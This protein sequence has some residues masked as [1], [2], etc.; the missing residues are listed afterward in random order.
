ME[1]GRKRLR[2]LHDFCVSAIRIVMK[3][4]LTSWERVRWYYVT[5]R[6]C[7]AILKREATS[8]FRFTSTVETGSNF[9]A[10]AAIVTSAATIIITMPTK[11]LLTTLYGALIAIWPQESLSRGIFL[12]NFGQ[13]KMLHLFRTLWRRRENSIVHRKITTHQLSPIVV[14]SC[15]R[16]RGIRHRHSNYFTQ[17]HRLD[18]SKLS[19]HTDFSTFAEQTRAAAMFLGNSSRETC[20]N[21]SALHNGYAI[22]KKSEEPRCRR[23]SRTADHP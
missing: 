11:W 2:L 16:Y 17:I 20:T 15:G 7:G 13:W 21:T 4:Y 23:T 18:Y 12:G 3:S 8:V 10:D 1:E 9:Y 22:N 6:K 5:W 19:S 14:A